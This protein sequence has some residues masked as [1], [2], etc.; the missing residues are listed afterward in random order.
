MTQTVGIRSSSQSISGSALSARPAG[1]S[2]SATT[3]PLAVLDRVGAC[4]V[5]RDGTA[6]RPR[7]R[8]PP[9]RMLLSGT[10]SRA[11]SASTSAPPPPQPASGRAQRERRALRVITARS[12]RRARPR[13]RPQSPPSAS[14]GA[15]LP[16]CETR[17]TSPRLAG[18]V[19]EPD[20]LVRHGDRV[21]EVELVRV[22]RAARRRRPRRPSRASATAPSKPST[23]AA[24]ARWT[25]GSARRSWP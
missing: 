20:P 17:T 23:A 6:G 18:R 24:A 21:A 19:V 13:A 25:R 11:A 1:S 4:R 14:R 22:L 3:A 15:T 5:D 8:R 10:T 16:P 9:S 2:P 7:T 12:A